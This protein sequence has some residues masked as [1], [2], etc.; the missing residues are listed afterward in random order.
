MDPEHARARPDGEDSLGRA[1]ERAPPAFVAW[2][3][4]PACSRSVGRSVSPCSKDGT[5]IEV[6]V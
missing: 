3:P 5:G 6:T 2:G 1:K 4:R